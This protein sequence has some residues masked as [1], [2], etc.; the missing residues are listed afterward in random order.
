MKEPNKFYICETEKITCKA[1]TL[2]NISSCS[3]LSPEI[4]MRDAFN[5]IL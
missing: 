2:Q 5:V 3:V 1:V 4:I